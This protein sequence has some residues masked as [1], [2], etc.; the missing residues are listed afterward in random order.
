MT[1]LAELVSHYGAT[2]VIIA[3]VI[4]I[5]L[6]SDFHFKYPRKRPDDHGI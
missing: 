6:R 5:V 4:Y 2:S 3:A 1:A